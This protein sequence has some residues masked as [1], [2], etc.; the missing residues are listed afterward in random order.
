M[1]SLLVQGAGSPVDDDSQNAAGETSPAPNPA[2][3]PMPGK[4]VVAAESRPVMP[5]TSR[6]AAYTRSQRRPPA[7]HNKRAPGFRAAHRADTLTLTLTLA[8]RQQPVAHVPP[9]AQ[10]GGQARRTASAVLSRRHIGWS[11]SETR[12]NNQG[13]SKSASDVT[14]KVSPDGVAGGNV[15][16]LYGVKGGEGRSVLVC[17]V[18]F[19]N[20]LVDSEPRKRAASTGTS[21]STAKQ[22]PW[23]QCLC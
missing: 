6:P 15:S 19:P 13:G 8:T 7:A 4:P 18:Q 1:Q 23:E 12:S 11:S 2:A 17:Q 5:K 16:I 3:A 14:L 20:I 9:S 10:H 22:T 21:Q